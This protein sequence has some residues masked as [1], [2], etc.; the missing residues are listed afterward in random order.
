[1]ENVRSLEHKM[2]ISEEIRSIQDRVELSLAAHILLSNTAIL[3][4]HPYRDYKPSSKYRG[5]QTEVPVNP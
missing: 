3:S 2:K 5:G 4:F 1:M